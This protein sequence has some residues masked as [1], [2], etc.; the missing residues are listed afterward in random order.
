MSCFQRIRFWALVHDED[1]LV[2]RMERFEISIEQL[3]VP[4][5]L[6]R[7][8]YW[9][10]G[11]IMAKLIVCSEGFLDKLLVEFPWLPFPSCPSLSPF[12]R[13]HPTHF[14]RHRTSFCH[15]L[16]SETWCGFDQTIVALIVSCSKYCTSALPSSWLRAPHQCRRERETLCCRGDSRPQRRTLLQR[17]YPGTG[18]DRRYNPGGRHEDIRVTLQMENSS[19]PTSKLLTCSMFSPLRADELYRLLLRLQQPSGK[20]QLD[21]VTK[22]EKWLYL[23]E[24]DGEEWNVMRAMCKNCSVTVKVVEYQLVNYIFQYCV[25]CLLQ[26][27]S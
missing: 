21:Q 10:S 15:L 23:S 11:E 18:T 20:K 24:G 1:W 13:E 25:A 26:C 27:M 3:E 22:Q 8:E 17:T 12:L 6:E 14:H 5:E 19:Q 7:Q 4:V 2:H 16:R 9:L